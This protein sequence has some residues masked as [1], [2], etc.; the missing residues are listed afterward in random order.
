[1]LE[2]SNTRTKSRLAPARI[3]AGGIS[4]RRLNRSAPQPFFILN[5]GSNPS[6]YKLLTPEVVRSS[7]GADAIPP[8][9]F[10]GGHPR[11]IPQGMILDVQ[12]LVKSLFCLTK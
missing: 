12:P 5:S 8:P 3:P 7:A 6:D 4:D 9:L 2:W 1:M 11:S 10:L